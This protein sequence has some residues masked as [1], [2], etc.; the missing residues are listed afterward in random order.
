MSRRLHTYLTALTAAAAVMLAACGRGDYR[1]AEGGMWST[2]YHITYKS[3]RQLDDSIIAVMREVE[4]SLSPFADSSLVSRVNR[5]E[6]TTVD[7]MFVKVFRGSVEVNR[8]SHGAFDPTVA[9]L[10][11]LWG[12][13]YRDGGGEPTAAM[14]DSAL[15]SV[16]IGDCRLEG[17]RIVKKS[18][19][20]EFNFSAITKGMG[21]DMVAAMLE[22]NGV[23]DYM[24]EIG[25]EI[26]LKGINER[27]DAWRIMI[28]APIEN[29][30][31]VVHERM[32]VIAPGNVG[33]A[34][35]GNYR[36]YRETAGGRVGHTIS[37][38][39]GRPVKTTTLSVTVVAP[40]CMMAD[41]LATACMAMSADEAR[42]MIEGIAG[43]GAMIVEGGD[44]GK[45]VITTT[46]GFPPIE[47]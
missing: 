29:D 14:I 5:N 12:F 36:N 26:A 24:V 9:P 28:D 35:S 3:D 41:A 45:Y 1:R 18:A 34:T 10:V 40:T 16:G 6:T 11:N 20:T 46:S 33:I 44:E 25:G 37:A 39:N 42:K 27:G 30:T 17:N 4:M 43:A 38:V 7:S 47:R 15:Q 22:R 23:S 13:G 2:L 8:L 21:V 32:A 19:G 31:A